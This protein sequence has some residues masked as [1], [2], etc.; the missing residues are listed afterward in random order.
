[1]KKPRIVYIKDFGNL[2]SDWNNLAYVYQ[3]IGLRTVKGYRSTFEVIDEKLF[4]YAIIKYEMVFKLIEIMVGEF[5]NTLL[6]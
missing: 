3:K 5:E 4:N 1:M 6:V 2:T